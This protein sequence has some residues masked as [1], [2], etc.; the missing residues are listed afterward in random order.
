MTGA[1][2]TADVQL[3]RRCYHTQKEASDDDSLAFKSLADLRRFR[4]G[5]AGGVLALAP[6]PA[7][8]CFNASRR[9]SG[10]SASPC[11]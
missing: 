3:W 7:P 2:L 8:M 6:S 4:R 10:E 1:T 11:A 9:L 5:A